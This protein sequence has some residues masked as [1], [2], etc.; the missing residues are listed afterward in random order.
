VRP[1]WFLKFQNNLIYH[2]MTLI[3]RVK[4]PTPKFFQKVRNG[5][6]ILGTI[7]A[8]LFAG[9]VALPP[10]LAKIAGYLAVAGGVASAVSQTATT[11]EGN[12]A[13]DDHHD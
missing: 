11:V 1:A 7:S 9:P 12:D 6:L 13:N 2:F 10:I 8:A 3:Q 5:G 4:Q